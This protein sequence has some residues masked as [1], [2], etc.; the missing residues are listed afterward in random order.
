MQK[1]GFKLKKIED[2]KFINN[3]PLYISKY[4]PNYFNMEIYK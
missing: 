4:V 1:Y 3:S 2:I